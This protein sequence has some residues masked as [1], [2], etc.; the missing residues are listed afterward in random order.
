MANAVARS[1]PSNTS[2]TFDR[3]AGRMTAPP[4]PWR[5]RPRMSMSSPEPEAADC[6]PDES[7]AVGGRSPF[8]GI[9]ARA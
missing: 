1:L 3:V 8:R 9:A 7:G 2:L 5:N 6:R 4:M